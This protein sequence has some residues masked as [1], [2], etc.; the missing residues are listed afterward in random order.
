[1]V[2]TILRKHIY[3][4]IKVAAYCIYKL[5]FVH[6]LCN[7]VYLTFTGKYLR[8]SLIVVHIATKV[9]SRCVHH[10]I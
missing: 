5:E 3:T 8:C 1:M 7:F 10:Q 4:I 6:F 2:I 9:P